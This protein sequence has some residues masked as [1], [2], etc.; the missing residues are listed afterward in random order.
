MLPSTME[1][2]ARALITAALV[3]PAVAIPGPVHTTPDHQH[4]SKVARQFRPPT[5]TTTIRGNVTT[6]TTTITSFIP[7]LPPTPSK[8]SSAPVTTISPPSELRKKSSASFSLDDNRCTTPGDRECHGELGGV[9]FCNEDHKWVSYAQCAEGAVCHRL[10]MVC[11]PEVIPTLTGHSTLAPT[12]TS[13]PF[14][15]QDNN[16]EKCKEGDRRC[17]KYFN[18]VDRCNADQ[19]WVTYHDCRRSEFCHDIILDC[20]PLQQVN[21]VFQPPLLR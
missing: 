11:I 6:Y 4:A 5:F 13:H 10:Y 20:L 17:D 3:V 12:P 2:L 15:L 18:R 1:R 16:E 9:L 7:S 21:F 8:V 14:G 19:D